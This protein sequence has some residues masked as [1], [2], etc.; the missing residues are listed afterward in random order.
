M[1][2][3][4]AKVIADSCNENGDRLITI[5]GSLPR[6]VLADFS[7][8]RVFSFSGQSTRAVPVKKMV[9][10]MNSNPFVPEVFGTNQAG[11]TAGYALEGDEAEA[12]RRIWGFAKGAAGDFATQLANLNVHKQLTGRLL[13]P[14]S[15]M[16]I[17]LTSTEWSNF[18]RLRR[19]KDAQP[20][21]QIFANKI[22]EA[23]ENSKP[24]VLSVNEWHLPYIEKKIVVTED[25]NGESILS[26]VYIADN[27]MV[28][29]D[30]AK[31][32]SAAKC[33]TTSYRTETLTV[34]KAMN[35]F[36]QLVV[37]DPQHSVPTEHVARPLE[38]N[39][40][41]FAD[42]L[43]THV[44]RWGGQWSGNFRSFGQY[45]KEIEL[46]HVQK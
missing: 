36:E 28:D 24:Q 46:Y 38:L 1:N 7:K 22:Y 10:L 4:Y 9:D 42:S 27:Q 19:H 12:A 45:R 21:L 26:T 18:F 37:S 13:E 32:Y 15:H 39:C 14:F 35:I 6:I 17:V 8:H 30:T 40:G 3:T 23:I 43:T 41:P 16:K 11:M 2:G 31:K 20:E 44:D 25:E 5:E 33:A 29:L 34:E